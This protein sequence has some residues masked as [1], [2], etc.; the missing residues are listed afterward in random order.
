[1]NTRAKLAGILKKFPGGVDEVSMTETGRIVA[2]VVSKSFSGCDE[3]VR[4]ARIWEYLYQQLSESE[5][6][7]I[8]FIFTNAPGE[9]RSEATAA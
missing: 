3:A 9:D 8:E 7:A 6:K 4:Q 1:M 5:L 2:I